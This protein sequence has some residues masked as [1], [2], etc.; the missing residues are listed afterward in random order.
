MH[1]PQHKKFSLL[2]LLNLSAAFDTVDHNILL[3]VLSSRFDVAG[4]AYDWF[5]SYLSGRTQS[6]CYNGQDTDGF[7]VNCSV[8][9]GSVLGPVKFAAYTEDIAELVERHSVRVHLYAD[10]TQLYDH[11]RPENVSTVRSRLTGCVSEVANWCAS[12]RLQLNADK[13]EVI[14]F[15]SKSNL[16][17][18]RS[19]DSSLS[20]GR[21][22]VQPVSVVRDLGVLLDAELSMRQ[23]ST[24]TIGG[25]HLLLPAAPTTT[26]STS[27]RPRSHNTVDPGTSHIT[28]GLL[29]FSLSRLATV[30]GRTTPTR[31]KLCSQ[32]AI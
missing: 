26:S 11:C 30:D 22:T 28:A 9:Q 31:A 16:A 32:A 24:S 29:Q 18:I 17:K 19:S 25:C 4:T 15:G 8:L 3:T 2:V 21:Q 6:F 12:R 14:W 27:R 10:D 1:S 23:N 20:V 5:E 13:T 7:P